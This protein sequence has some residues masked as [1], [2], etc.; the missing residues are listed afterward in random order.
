M[1]IMAGIEAVENCFHPIQ[2][3]T[4]EVDG[5]TVFESSCMARATMGC[6]K[7]VSW[8]GQ[9]LG[10]DVDLMLRNGKVKCTANCRLRRD[11][12]SGFFGH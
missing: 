9:T 6:S 11:L 7:F 12:K 3:V 8:D 4:T 5:V 2:T 10:A 1:G